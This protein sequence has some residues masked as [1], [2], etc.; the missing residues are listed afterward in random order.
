MYEESEANII[1]LH[2]FPFIHI[3]RTLEHTYIPFI[4][5]KMLPP[6]TF[7]VWRATVGYNFDQLYQ[8]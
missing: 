8:L 5:E 2:S 1:S 6:S 3:K 4:M 7:Y